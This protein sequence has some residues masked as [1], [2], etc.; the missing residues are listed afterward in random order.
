MAAI[1]PSCPR[2]INWTHHNDFMR[3]ARS[4]GRPGLGFNLQT[5]PL[6]CAPKCQDVR[7]HM[8]FR[9]AWSELWPVG[10]EWALVII[11][12]MIRLRLELPAQDARPQMDFSLTSPGQ[13]ERH[14]RR[15]RH[16]AT[17]DVGWFLESS[18]TG[19]SGRTYNQN[20][21][22]DWGALFQK[23]PVFITVF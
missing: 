20:G 11:V 22:R 2:F 7:W 16:I 9:L 18:G 8:D 3:L 1:L 14:K 10:E 21:G 17:C 19:E 12:I 5:P 6:G 4:G 13:M 23:N 15:E